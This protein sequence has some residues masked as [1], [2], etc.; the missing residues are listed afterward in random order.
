MPACPKCQSEVGWRAVMFASVLGGVVCPACRASLEPEPKR[1]TTLNL[2]AI[3]AGF[4]VQYVLRS[5]GY[6]LPLQLAGLL[7]GYAFLWLLFF[8][9]VVHLREKRPSVP[10]IR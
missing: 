6:P 5:Q 8:D 7:G 9:S 3:L 4:A 10:S 2:V 1:Y